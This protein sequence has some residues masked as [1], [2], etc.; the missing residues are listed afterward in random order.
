MQVCI[1]HHVCPWCLWRL[2]VSTQA[3]ATGIIDG[4]EL[5]ATQEEQSVNLTPGI[6]WEVFFMCVSMCLCVCAFV[7]LYESHM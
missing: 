5:P 2:E 6:F 3:P 7:C 4:F 1:V